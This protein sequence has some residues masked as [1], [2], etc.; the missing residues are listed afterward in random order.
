MVNEIGPEAC[1]YLQDNADSFGIALGDQFVIDF[2]GKEFRGGLN[3]ICDGVR[4]EINQSPLYQRALAEA[5]LV[6]NQVDEQIKE[7]KKTSVFEGV[8]GLKN[9]GNTCYMNSVVQAIFH[10]T[11]FNRL[12]NGELDKAPLNKDALKGPTLFGVLHKTFVDYKDASIAKVS[13]S[14]KEL[15]DARRHSFSN[16]ERGRTDDAES[17]LT[18]ML[19]VLDLQF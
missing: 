1:N 17:F 9:C 4:A 5:D 12:L 14:T 16:F 8:A 15:A 2:E 10:T 6:I 3:Q 11:D 13:T 19:G 18:V 7:I